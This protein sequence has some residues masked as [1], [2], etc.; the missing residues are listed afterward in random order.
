LLVSH[1]TAKRSIFIS[2]L[3]FEELIRPGAMP[4]IVGSFLHNF[5]KNIEVIRKIVY[6]GT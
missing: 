2:F 6:N 3:F 5:P 1:R 4:G